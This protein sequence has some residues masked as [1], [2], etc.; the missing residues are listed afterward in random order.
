MTVLEEVAELD[1]GV[2]MFVGNSCGGLFEGAGEEVEGMEEL[3]FVRDGWMR[4][5][6]VAEFNSVGD[7]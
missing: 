2:E 7:E 5:V 1:D 6:V 4:E 3:I